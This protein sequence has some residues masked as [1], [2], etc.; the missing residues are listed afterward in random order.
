MLYILAISV[1]V[2]S[3]LLYVT[4]MKELQPE[5]ENSLVKEWICFS[6]KRWILIGIY[7]IV[8]FVLMN[9]FVIYGFGPTKMVKYCLL[10]G[11]LVPIAYE[12]YKE[13]RIPNRWLLY[14][15]GIRAVLFVVETCL[16]PSATISNIIFALGGGMASGILL[17][18]AYVLSRHEIGLGDVK[19]FIVIGLYL[20]ASVTYFVILMSLI[21]AAVYSGI[22]L[23]RKKMHVK[24]EI[25]FGPFI[26][27]GTLIILALGF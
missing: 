6:K 19:L 22:K 25:P 10:L 9:L 27:L 18:I 2:I 12:D 20:G 11:G 17:F 3:Y 13:K 26:L 7:L 23:L 16:Y 4:C 5:N 21:V 1:T 15:I 14:L 24:D 8:S